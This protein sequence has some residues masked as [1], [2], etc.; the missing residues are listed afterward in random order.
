MI[1]AGTG[2]SAVEETAPVAS[3]RLQPSANANEALIVNV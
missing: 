1:M 2:K 3:S